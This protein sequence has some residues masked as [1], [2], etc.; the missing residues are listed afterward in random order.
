MRCPRTASPHSD[1]L[2]P[3]PSFKHRPSLRP[4]VCETTGWALHAPGTCPRLQR[5]KPKNLHWEG[6]H[7]DAPSE[8]EE[9]LRVHLVRKY[10][11]APAKGS[12]ETREPPEG[13]P[14]ADSKA[15]RGGRRS[16]GP[17][18]VPLNSQAVAAVAGSSVMF[19]GGSFFTGVVGSSF[20]FLRLL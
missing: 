10:V 13:V 14:H 8:E 2:L 12:T 7:T 9:P 20:S 16:E 6:A 5:P 18:S 19:L 1:S 4:P 17:R 3:G 11:W 15:S